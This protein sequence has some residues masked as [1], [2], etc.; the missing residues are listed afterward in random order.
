MAQE[1]PNRV[2]GMVRSIDQ[3]RNGDPKAI[4]S[5][6]AAQVLYAVTDARQDILALWAALEGAVADIA[7]KDAEIARQKKALEF[8]RDGFQ[9]RPKRGPTGIN[10]S[11]WK[12][13]KA[14][15]DDCGN[16]AVEALTPSKA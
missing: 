1:K 16:V 4:C 15:L 12:V 8:Y 13:T 5:G 14:L 7:A 11:E 10:H 9:F 2:Q 3:Y 6:S